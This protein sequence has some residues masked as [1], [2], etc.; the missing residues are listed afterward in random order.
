MDSPSR[1]KTHTRLSSADERRRVATP[2]RST[3]GP[4]DAPVEDP[5]GVT[6]EPPSAADSV[7]S[8]PPQNARRPISPSISLTSPRS[9]SSNLLASQTLGDVPPRDFSYILQPLNYH[10]LPPTTIPPPFI[11]SAHQPDPS[12]P[13]SALLR[14]GHFRH[15]AIAA[16]HALSDSTDPTDY[17]QIFALLYTR[18]SCLT[19]LGQHALAAQEAKVLGDL[20]RSLYRHPLT[21]EHLV[22]WELRVLAVRLQ[23]HGFGEGRRGIMGYYELARDARTAILK[24]VDAVEKDLWTAR[25]EEL[26]VRVASALIEMGDLEGAA[27]HLRT[28]RADTEG[29][30]KSLRKVHELEAMVWLKVGDV[31]AAK[32]CLSLSS[33][34]EAEANGIVKALILTVG[35]NYRAAADAWADLHNADPDDAMILQNLAICKLYTGYVGEARDLLSSIANTGPSFHSLTFNLATVYELCSEKPHV[36]KMELAARLADK[37]PTETGWERE[38]VDFKL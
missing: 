32:R 15:A 24:A 8:P 22:P 5:L 20:S 33:S 31:D 19:V 16:V 11:Q 26:G 27:R 12:T 29:D 34:D 28:L 6:S 36:S 30:M 37:E 10:N 17:Q 13:I 35:G 18:L 2:R 14:N 9:T 3:K 25:L 38:S 23:A 7:L 21:N 1:S 4:L